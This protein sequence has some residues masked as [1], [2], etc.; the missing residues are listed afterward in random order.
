MASLA[1]KYRP[2]DFSDLVGQVHAAQ[3]LKN[4]IEFKNIGHAYLFYGSRGV[5]KTSTARI[6]AKALNCEKGPTTEPCGVCSHCIEISK[7]TSMD[8]IEMD[9]ASNRGIDHIRELRENVRFAPMRARYK[10]YIIDEVH[11]LTTES[12]N[13]LLK[14]L[15]EPPSHVVFILATTEMHKI[16]ETILS[17]C[18]SFA[19]RRF[20]LKEI[21]ARLTYI[22][23]E[24][25]K[26]YEEEALFP[27]AEKADGS[28]RDAISLLDQVA[29]FAGKE[30]MTVAMVGIVL[31]IPRQELFFEFLDSIRNRNTK[32]AF[33][34]IHTLS[35]EGQNLRRF[36]WDVL[37]I[38]KNITVLKEIPDT[39]ELNIS[40][41]L[42]DELVKQ[43]QAWD[44]R[45]L[46]AFF[47]TLFAMY[48]SPSLYSSS[49]SSEVRIAFEMALLD[50]FDK[51]TRPSVSALLSRLK[52]LESALSSGIPYEEKTPTSQNSLPEKREPA[53]EKTIM[54]SA[55][56]PAAPQPTGPTLEEMEEAESR[57]LLE[58][59]FMAEEVD[60]QTGSMFQ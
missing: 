19:F 60:A 8:V 34:I 31:G 29:A 43:G 27:I 49:R 24:E 14:T 6:L 38:I 18:Q 16:P 48:S 44:S 30:K 17:R 41:S 46:M 9:A 25:K 12:F 45:E 58:R 28:M 50:L 5:G 1:V 22:L 39:A 56:V 52:G 13:A 21:Q 53:P 37:T 3:S 4:A 10:I 47:D 26:E 15:E 7:G 36:I 35:E 55:P 51:L 42:R 54:A 23:K 40:P 32:T 57:A 20:S 11:M 2:R 59:E 33:H